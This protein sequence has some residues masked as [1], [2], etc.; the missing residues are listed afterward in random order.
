[1]TGQEMEP[2]LQL[3]YNQKEGRNQTGPLELCVRFT[4][5]VSLTHFWDDI[6]VINLGA[7]IVTF[8]QSVHSISKSRPMRVGGHHSGR[9][10]K[11]A[12]LL[13]LLYFYNFYRERLKSFLT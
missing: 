6:Y 7:S 10:D 5:C 13:Y 9:N 1:M 2:I 8:N 3:I 12:M 11:I 4:T